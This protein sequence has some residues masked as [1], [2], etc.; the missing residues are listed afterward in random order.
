M[1]LQP[2]QYEN[3]ISQIGELLHAGRQKALQSVNTILVRTYW[4]IGCYIVEFEQEGN[5]S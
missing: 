2:V 5:I 4:K 3:L 1:E